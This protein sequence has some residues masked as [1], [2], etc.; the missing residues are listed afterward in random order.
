MH[1]RA[2]S[3][4]RLYIEE[5]LLKKLDYVEVFDEEMKGLSDNF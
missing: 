2:S 5:K 4:S 3:V 1:Q